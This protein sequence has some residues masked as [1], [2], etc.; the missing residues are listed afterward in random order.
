MHAVDLALSTLFVPRCAS[1]DARVAPGQ[2]LC[3]TCMVSVDPL[4]PACPHCA[5]PME[6]PPLATAP[7]CAR[8]RRTPPPYELLIAP[9]RFGGELARVLRR[10]KFA[11]RPELAREL[12]PMLVP[13][14]HEVV[15]TAAIDVVVPVPL[16]WRRLAGRGYNQAQVLAAEMLAAA[17][18]GLIRAG[19]PLRL[20]PLTL[21]RRRATPPQTG[22]SAAER[23]R[24]LAGAFAVAPRRAA[25][26]RG[27]RVL[28][29]DD[30]ATTGATIAEATR[31][32]LAAGAAAVVGFTVARAGD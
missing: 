2:P 22:L 10:L 12:A 29:V 9:W 6:L 27:R 24:N 16:H 5:E 17:R 11:G 30:V 25:R 26:L 14:F 18:P 21:R 23:A 32:L 8:C 7:I 19:H 4:G 20:D 1:C 3:A 15:V 31:T 13:F 28:V